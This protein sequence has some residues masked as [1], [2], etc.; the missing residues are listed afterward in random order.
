[1]SRLSDDH[2]PAPAVVSAPKGRRLVPPKACISAP[3]SRRFDAATR[4]KQPDI[5]PVF[6]KLPVRDEFQ[7]TVTGTKGM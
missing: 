4:K 6:R 5:F 1:M 2:G 7:V 3:K